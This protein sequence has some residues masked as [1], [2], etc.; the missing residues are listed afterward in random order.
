M[1]F[2]ALGQLQVVR[3]DETLPLGSTK[4]RALLAMLL[5][6]RNHV[7]STDQL[8]DELWGADAS[9]DRK[10]SLHVYLSNLRKILEPDRAARESSMIVTRSPG[11]MINTDSAEVDVDDFERLVAEGRA[12]VNSDPAS[13]SIVLGEGLALWRGKPYEEFTYESFAQ[14]EI[15]RLSELRVNAVETRIDADLARGL[16]RELIA[17][18]EGLVR[19]HPLRERF[20]G[21][22][23]IALYR[24]GRHAEALRSYKRLQAA[25]AEELGI[26]PST[27]LQALE[28]RVLVGDPALTVTSPDMLP[29]GGPAPGLAVRGYELR[30]RIGA[31]RFG[32]AYRA[33]Q[34]A[35]G[36]EVAVKVI[37]PELADDAQFVR[38]FDDEAQLVARLEHPNIVPLYDYWRE[39]G[40]G[41]LVMR[42]MQGGSLDTAL[43]SGPLSPDRVAR[44]VAE[45]GSA[46][47]L[48]HKTGVMHLDIK[49]SNILIDAEGT[50]LLSDFGI[51]AS[52]PG[53][54]A[55]LPTLEPPY[56]PPEL[57]DGG[58]LSTSSDVYSLAVVAAQSLT[59]RTGEISEQMVGMDARI[60]EVLTKATAVDP[61]LRYDDVGSFVEDFLEAVGDGAAPST[62]RRPGPSNPY[63]GLRSFQQADTVDFHG[64]ERLVERILARLGS[65]GAR[66]RLVA[67]VGPSG[68]GKSSAVKAGVLP[69]LKRGG[70][71]DSAS[72]YQVEMTPGPHPFSALEE[73]LISVA[74]NQPASLLDELAA[75]G[76]IH[77]AVDRVLPGSD[78][79]LVI[80]IDQFEELYTLA[81]PAVANRFLAALVEAITAQPGRVRVVITLRADFYDRPLSHRSFGELLRHC[82]EVLTPM[83]HEEMERAISGPAR[84][85]GVEY[86]PALL[87]EIL[88]EVTDRPGALPLLQYALT[89]LFERRQG[90]VITTSVYRSIGGVAGALGE[91][92][93][94]LFKGLEGEAQQVTKQVFLRLVTLGE[95]VEDT[96][97]RVVMSE[98]LS[99]Q[100]AGPHVEAVVQAFGRH[101]LLSFDRDPI[102]RGPTVEISHEALLAEWPRLKKWIDDARGDIRAQRRLSAAAEE[103]AERSEDSGYL[104]TGPRLTRFQGWLEDAPVELTASERRFLEACAA[105]Q[106][107]EDERARE[108]ALQK[109]RLRRRSRGL[110]GVAIFA[111]IAIGL[112]VFAI[113]ERQRSQRLAAELSVTERARHL[114]GLSLFQVQGDPELSVMLA[115]EAARSTADDGF[116]VPEA[117]DAIHASIQSLN[118]QYPV[119]SEAQFALRGTRGVF[120]MPPNELIE[121]AQT[122][123]TR[124]LTDDECGRLFPEEEC[125]DPTA[126][127]PAGLVVNGDYGQHVG[128][129][130]LAGATVTIRGPQQAPQEVAGLEAMYAVVE[131]KTGIDIEYEP[132]T[133]GPLDA[134]R[135]GRSG[136]IVNIP[137]PAT[138][139]EL[140]AE[141]RLVDLSQYI[142]RDTLVDAFGDYLVGLT[143]V[144]A[145]ASWPSQTGAVY[146]VWLKIEN[147]SLI[148]HPVPEFSER[149]LPAPVSWGDLIDLSDQLVA[150]GETPFCLGV[151]SGPASGWP[152]TDWLES[153]LLRSH[154]PQVY[155]QWAAHEIPFDHPAIVESLEKVGAM[156]FTD[157]YVDEGPESVVIRDYWAGGVQLTQNPPEC[158]LYPQA[159]WVPATVPTLVSGVTGDVFDF[160]VINPEFEATSVV[161]GAFAVAM[162]DRPEVRIVMEEMASAEFGAP[163]AQLGGWIVPHRNFGLD[164]Y[165]IPAERH[166]A[167]LTIR[168]IE[169]GGARF[170]A[171]DLMPPH[172]GQG[173]FWE[174][175]VRYFLEGPDAGP[176]ILADIEESWSRP[177]GGSG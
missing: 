76:G 43:H 69:A 163:A 83:S 162:A 49:P 99:L 32:I 44:L 121:F 25:L 41:Y 147:K 143:S 9:I 113:I 48:A 131:E 133:G 135:E 10:N 116:V 95:G 148:W 70:V 52:G 171:S 134:V 6:N 75:E 27:E 142:G 88:A 87:G 111:V 168:A 102:S 40:A 42:L 80:V 109:E 96:R 107:L 92:A 86:E 149:G 177:P 79:Q 170:D 161:A 176:Q 98:L 129:A 125:P 26:L 127:L 160:P 38:A 34:P 151:A 14:A 67:V 106:R 7:V 13:A 17:E 64:R 167:E 154:G 55:R 126:A 53:F 165:A 39:P 123:I 89:E 152:G 159:S 36:R 57:R 150:D 11:Y 93:E 158:W 172:V 174:G 105:Q 15:S 132:F 139:A 81:D 54:D 138:V 108:S 21:Q 166:I 91:R 97:R 104:L 146:G 175:M 137:Q 156:A 130:G 164:G 37:R 145:D 82:T 144:G 5:I 56:S 85:L 140:V 124:D 60:V 84:R 28:E 63:K 155:D 101:R 110:V 120:L 16:A 90:Q 65:T 4:Q 18:L 153:V 47:D 119:G 122:L 118:A 128:V 20:A 50:A 112:S 19:E 173:T 136:D 31:G 23:M 2:K 29:G 8:V 68:S 169:S 114:T 94:S 58:R 30:E 35:V 61:D 71:V 78:S 117:L 45:V 157:G 141:R 33:F 62:T 77:R 59:G 103:W 100:G 66:S 73:A 22:L 12:L 115:V 72:W 46:L 1:Y 74:V 51:A 24:T 3:D